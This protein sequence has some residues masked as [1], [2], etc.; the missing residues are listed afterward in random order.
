MQHRK[1]T[2]SKRTDLRSRRLNLEELESRLAPSTTTL[3]RE[4]GGTGYT[5][6]TFDDT[7]LSSWTPTTTHGNETY[8]Y[9]RN[10]GDGSMYGA[11]LLAV[12]DLFSVL[13]ARDANDRAI[14]INYAKLHLTS[15]FGMDSS[16]QITVS[17]MTNGA[18]LS[19]TAGSNENNVS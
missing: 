7:Y 5:P 9:Q 10:N 13:P 19:N 17:R 4:G 12:K 2:K 6:A 18:W 15:V 3:F 8:T 1:N 14:S 11:S 16:D